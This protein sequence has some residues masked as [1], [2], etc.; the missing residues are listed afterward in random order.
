M[1]TPRVHSLHLPSST[2]RYPLA[3]LDEVDT[4][5]DVLFHRNII[6]PDDLCQW[7]V[8]ALDEQGSSVQNPQFQ[9]LQ[10][11]IPQTG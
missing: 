7:E 10:R 6:D 8:F 5:T 3:P 2:I 4:G 11:L 9:Y 1:S